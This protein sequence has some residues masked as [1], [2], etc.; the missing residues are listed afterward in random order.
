MDARRIATWVAGAVAAAGAVR[1]VLAIGVG[2][3]SLPGCW[4]L[5]AGAGAVAAATA[6]RGSVRSAAIGAAIAVAA[7]GAL[8]GAE[9]ATRPGRPALPAHALVFT[10][11]FG[12]F[13]MP[14]P[15]NFAEHSGAAADTP[16]A[17]HRQ[18]RPEPPDPRGVAVLDVIVQRSDACTFAQGEPE[19]CKSHRDET[20]GAARGHAW[21]TEVHG[22]GTLAMELHVDGF[23][24]VAQFTAA[25]DGLGRLT[26]Y[27]PRIEQAFAGL[28]LLPTDPFT[29]WDRRWFGR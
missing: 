9:L 12:L 1:A 21:R 20:R 3:I 11:R 15:P 17:T 19:G 16:N 29:R 27:Q 8:T 5:A 25:L 22:A 14:L 6:R 26:D 2:G 4:L 23:R 28:R 7:A 10:D 13:W 24:F 18:Y